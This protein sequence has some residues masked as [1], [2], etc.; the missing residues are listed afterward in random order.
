MPATSAGLPPWYAVTLRYSYSIQHKPVHH[1]GTHPTHLVGGDM[2]VHHRSA[3]GQWD[4]VS[5]RTA[6][7]LPPLPCPAHWKVGA[8][9]LA[10]GPFQVAV[11]LRVGLQQ[12]DGMQFGGQG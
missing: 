2:A 10:A 1:D 12:L 3:F 5:E 4:V 9:F 6:P 7:P 11:D 8:V